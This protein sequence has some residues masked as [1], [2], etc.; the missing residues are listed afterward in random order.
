V[1]RSSLSLQL[2]LKPLCNKYIFNKDWYGTSRLFA[3]SLRRSSIGLG[4]RS[5]I[6][7]DEGLRL[8]GIM[9]FALPQSTK[10]VESCVDQNSRSA[11]SLLN[12]GSPFF[13]MI[14]KSFAPYDL[15][16]APR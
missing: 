3:R 13:M 15:G 9:R 6:V 2:S 1:T 5:E 11:S 12:L 14:G 10:S 16:L 8:G 7:C 4:R